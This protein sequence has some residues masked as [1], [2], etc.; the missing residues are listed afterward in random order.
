MLRASTQII[1]VTIVS[2][3]LDSY[4]ATD[5]ISQENLKSYV[6]S[7][8]MSVS[9]ASVCSSSFLASSYFDSA[10]SRSSV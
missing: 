5:Y 10:C 1:L 6:G 2:K 7:A 9:S 8:H 4:S 3:K